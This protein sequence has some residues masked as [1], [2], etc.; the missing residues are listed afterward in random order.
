MYHYDDYDLA[1]EWQNGYTSGQDSVRDDVAEV[2]KRLDEDKLD[3]V[4]FILMMRNL[5]RQ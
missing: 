2:L 5:A 4:D 1:S 3:T